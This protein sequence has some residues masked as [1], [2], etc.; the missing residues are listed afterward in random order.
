MTEPDG[1]SMKARAKSFSYAGRGVVALVREQHNARI[2][3]VTTVVVIAAA[4]FFRVSRLEWCALLL[5]IAIVWGA[6]ALNTAIEHLADAA[7]PERHPLVGKAKDAAAGGV[8][9]CA[10]GAALV[11]GVIFLPHLSAWLAA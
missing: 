8:L 10:I 11:A 4:A 6:E 7:V 5:A 9:L 1:F 2:H 3:L